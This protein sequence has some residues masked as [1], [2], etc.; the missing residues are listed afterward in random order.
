VHSLYV[1]AFSN[2]LH[3][4]FLVGAVISGIAFVLSWFLTEVPLR[5][6][7]EPAVAA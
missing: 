4:V 7:T 1:H 2:A 6:T 3:P 5:R